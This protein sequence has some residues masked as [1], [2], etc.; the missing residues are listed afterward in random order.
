MLIIT[1]PLMAQ[2]L[3]SRIGPRLRWRSLSQAMSIEG[4]EITS[5]MAAST[6]GY[7][8]NFSPST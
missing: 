3:A 8:Q 1:R 4:V 2:P 7:C 5:M 6:S